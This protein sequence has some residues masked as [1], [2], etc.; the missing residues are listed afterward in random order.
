MMKKKVVS[1]LLVVCMVLSLFPVGAVAVQV[2]GSEAEDSVVL[3][4]EQA[5]DSSAAVEESTEAEEQP[6]ESSLELPDEPGEPVSDEPEIKLTEMEKAAVPVTL[7]SYVWLK[8]DCEIEYAPAKTTAQADSVQQWYDPSQMLDGNLTTLW[9]ASWSDAPDRPAI[10]LTL[11]AAE[12]VTGFMYMSR[13]DNY[14]GGIMMDYAVYVSADGTTYGETP[15]A[16]GTLPY[17]LGTFFVTFETPVLAKGVKIVST[18]HSIAEMRLTYQPNDYDSL[19]AEATAVREAADINQWDAAA[20]EAFDAGLK[21]VTDAGKPENLEDLRTACLSLF[22]LIRD[23]K[24]AK[25]ASTEDLCAQYNQ[26]KTLR[27]AAVEG[28]GGDGCGACGR[29]ACC[30]CHGFR[31]GRGAGC[32]ADAGGRSL[33]IPSGPGEA[34]SEH[35]PQQY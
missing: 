9:Q 8:N 35:D 1:L 17:K 30:E 6:E 26:A 4:P 16:E 27:D 5:Q 29:S 19:L 31:T 24:R 15:V 33:C 20:L 25:S 28:T 23:L 7:D 12:Y 2:G 13:Q 11:Q 3:A 32:A 34:E 10:T 21:V 18:G 22:A 14:I